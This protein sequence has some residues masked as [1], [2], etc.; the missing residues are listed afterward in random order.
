MRWSGRE[1][2][3]D[4]DA[5]GPFL[6]WIVAV[7]VYL[8]SLAVAA[9]LLVNQVTDRWQK[10]LAGGL[11][12]QVPPPAAEDER[13]GHDDRIDELVERL[14]NWPGVRKAE[15]L[16]SAEIADLLEPWLGEAGAY[17]G[18]PLPALI[19]VEFSP[20]T[21]IDLEALAAELREAARVGHGAHIDH[22]LDASRLQQVDEAPDRMVG[23][24]DRLDHAV[25]R[26]HQC[27]VSNR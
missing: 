13:T 2:P 10:D 18:L 22:R 7:M 26:D 8:A 25:S 16:G 15:R 1:V 9:A 21:A 3:L 19:A 11:T 17:D 5:S 4:S 27:S 6:P 23:M 20:G 14:S 24:A 12:V